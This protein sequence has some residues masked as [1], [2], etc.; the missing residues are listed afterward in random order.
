MKKAELLQK[1]Y[2]LGKHARHSD[3]IFDGV[4]IVAPPVLEDGPVNDG[5]GDEQGGD[6]GVVV[7]APEQ[8]AADA[9]VDK[10]KRSSMA[11]YLLHVLKPQRCHSV[12]VSSGDEPTLYFQVLR[13]SSSSWTYVKPLQSTGTDVGDLRL[14]L[15]AQ[16]L[17]RRPG[18]DEDE[19]WVF[20]DGILSVWTC[21]L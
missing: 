15:Y 11:Q 16:P 19:R 17:T 13:V 5:D 18:G 3:D 4:D 1:V 2:H 6:E 12:P 20:P 9:M 14:Y 10:V 8:I 7:L 21:L